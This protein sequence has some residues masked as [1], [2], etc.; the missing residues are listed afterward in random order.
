MVHKDFS[1][2]RPDAA[3][4]IVEALRTLRARYGQAIEQHDLA[5]AR[6]CAKEA[7]AFAQLLIDNLTGWAVDDV[8]QSATNA[9][10]IAPR[11]GKHRRNAKAG[12]RNS[13]RTLIANMIAIGGIVPPAYRSELQLALKALN[14]GEVRPLLR[15]S[16]TGRWREPFSLSE[17][18]QLAILHVFYRWG[19]GGTKKA[20]QEI[21]ASA[22]GVA[23]ST[24]RTWETS[25]LLEVNDNAPASWKIA[26]RAGALAQDFELNR[27]DSHSDR[28]A[29]VMHRFLL[30]RPLALV[31]KGY[32]SAVGIGAD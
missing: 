5:K 1:A 8:I 16:L 29:L 14:E 15:P 2:D 24:L 28:A 12:E 11:K 26:R 17:Y 6:R 31:A 13:D 32:K 9:P 19:S 18:W 7:L 30:S 3:E 4:L 22:L 21:V 27:S 20:A 23:P 10:K 25:A